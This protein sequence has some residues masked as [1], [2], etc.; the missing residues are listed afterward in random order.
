MTVG[1]EMTREGRIVP[2]CRIGF[3]GYALVLGV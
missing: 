2:V 3:A 1:G